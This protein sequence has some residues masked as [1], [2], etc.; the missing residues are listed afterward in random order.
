MGGFLTEPP[1]N[2]STTVYILLHI[3]ALYVYGCIYVATL[4]CV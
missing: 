3:C 1:Y 4:D 2:L